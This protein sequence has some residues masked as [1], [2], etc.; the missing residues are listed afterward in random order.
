[1]S[2]EQRTARETLIEWGD[3]VAAIHGWPGAPS[4][5]AVERLISA[6]DCLAAALRAA[7]APTDVAATLIRYLDEQFGLA[8]RPE[9]AREIR[10]IL[11]ADRTQPIETPPENRPQPMAAPAPVDVQAIA[12]IAWTCI[13]ECKGYMPPP[14]MCPGHQQE[15]Q[16]LV[17][18]VAEPIDP[19]VTGRAKCRV[20]S[21]VCQSVA[22]LGADLDNLECP[23]CHRM[24]LEVA[25]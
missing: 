1:M 5:F 16:A 15:A 19:H 12:E 21:H 23:N 14:V 4:A 7:P 11:A 2:S 8:L 9:H 20:C 22:P 17:G 25:P 18:A 24:T 13:K 6:G 3:A 10:R